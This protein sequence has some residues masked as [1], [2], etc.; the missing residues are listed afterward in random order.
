MQI[1]SNFKSDLILVMK[2]NFSTL[3]VVINRYIP[4]INLKIV[5]STYSVHTAYAHMCV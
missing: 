5:Q 2:F 4:K 3:Y 1:I